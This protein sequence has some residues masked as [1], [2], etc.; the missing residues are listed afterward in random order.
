MVNDEMM[1]RSNY[2]DQLFF[3]QFQLG[4]NTKKFLI[5]NTL[6]EVLDKEN[7]FEND[8]KLIIYIFSRVTR[9]QICKENCFQGFLRFSNAV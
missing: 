2:V 6:N 8:V 7:E 1:F 4:T 3:A 5:N 9:S